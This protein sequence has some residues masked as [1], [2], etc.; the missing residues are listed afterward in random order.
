MSTHV[1][2]LC[3]ENMHANMLLVLPLCHRQKQGNSLY[4]ISTIHF[5]KFLLPTVKQASIIHFLFGNSLHLY[6]NDQVRC[7][8]SHINVRINTSWVSKTNLYIVSLNENQ[9]EKFRN[10]EG[11]VLALA[12]LICLRQHACG[13]PKFQ[14]KSTK[15]ALSLYLA[16][17]VIYRRTCT[18]RI[19]DMS[20]PKASNMQFQLETPGCL[21]TRT[22]VLL[23]DS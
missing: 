14:L 22:C 15:L 18:K 4:G 23:F 8:W 3:R 6:S 11:Y 7:V 16:L 1:L 12:S 9:K 21:L 10:Q 5:L 19:G 17:D 2:V 20:T 13:L